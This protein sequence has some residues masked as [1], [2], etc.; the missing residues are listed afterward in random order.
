MGD[1]TLCRTSDPTKRIVLYFDT[2]AAHDSTFERVP[3]RHPYGSLFAARVIG[4]C[5]NRHNLRMTSR[6]VGVPPMKTTHKNNLIL[7]KLGQRPPADGLEW[8][9]PHSGVQKSRVIGWH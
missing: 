4:D 8:T 1:A 7:S 6:Y 5:P 9:T 3:Q 2:C